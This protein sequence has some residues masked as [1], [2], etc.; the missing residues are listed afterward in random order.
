[1][2][3]IFGLGN[4]GE[5]YLNTRH[6][7]GFMVLDKL[8]AHPEL[9]PVEDTLAFN[10]DKRLKARLAFTLNKGEKIILV[11]PE[12]FMNA[13]G[14]AVQSVMNYY[15]A[16]P[17]ELI[18]VADDVD[19]PLGEARIRTEGGSAGQRGLQNIIDTLGSEKFARVRMG[20]N[21]GKFKS[22]EHE[23]STGPIDTADYVLQPFTEREV[24]LFDH[25]ADE[26]VDYLIRT[27]GAKDPLQATSIRV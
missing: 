27:I 7:A 2:K 16:N 22:A 4:P 5:R 24:P 20:V 19:I 1:M 23:T 18:V 14:L 11:K 6:N 21:D 3:I 10:L 8:A 26:V 9:S 15:K 25:I 13:S 17:E 12:T